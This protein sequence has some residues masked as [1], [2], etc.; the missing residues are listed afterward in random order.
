[1]FRSLLSACSGHV[2]KVEIL[3]SNTVVVVSYSPARDPGRLKADIDYDSFNKTGLEISKITDAGIRGASP[4]SS[5]W[6]HSDK[7]YR[8][9]LEGAR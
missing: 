8:S 5:C 6:Q 7:A 1:M 4:G 9:V 3:H 2:S